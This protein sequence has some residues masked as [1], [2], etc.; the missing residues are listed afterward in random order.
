MSDMC[1]YNMNNFM[2]DAYFCAPSACT[3]KKDITM[4][5]TVILAVSIFVLHLNELILRIS[6]KNINNKMFKAKC[7]N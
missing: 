2:T 7:C 5:D 1:S 4:V 6:L 3:A